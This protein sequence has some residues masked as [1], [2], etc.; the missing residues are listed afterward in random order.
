MRLFAIS[1][2]HLPGGQEKP[3]NVFGD[4]WE[5]HFDRIAASWRERVSQE[6]TVLLAGDT[7]WAMQLA[8]A[9]ADLRAV[10]AL[11]G[12][13]L[14]LKGN[15]DY[16]WTTLSKMRRVMP[17]SITLIQH[18]AVDLG[19]CVVCGSRG[20]VFPMSGQTMT[21]EDERLCQRETLRLDMALREAEKIAADRPI[22]V[23]MHF[24]PL[25]ETQRDTPFTR[26]IGQYPVSQVIYGHLHG[27]GIRAGFCGT[28]EGV[29][30][31]LTSCD[32]L[33][34][35]VAEIPLA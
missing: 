11:P 29:R 24:P 12:R 1:D 2:L 25:F 9:E 15:H 21:E 8:D 3:M 14:L 5:G 31:R 7:S 6:D 10:A 18:S 28:H 32:A 34:F 20:W 30:Y 4:H 16:W 33:E 27:A 26:V 35:H 17:P 13:K 22:L 23:M 19:P